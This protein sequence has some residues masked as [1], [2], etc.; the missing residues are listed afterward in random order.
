[1][2]NAADRQHIKSELCALMEEYQGK[3][4]HD[5]GVRYGLEQAF[6]IVVNAPDNAPDAESEAKDG[7]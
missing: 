4:S 2:S 7:T 1:M 3:T 6:K 5:R